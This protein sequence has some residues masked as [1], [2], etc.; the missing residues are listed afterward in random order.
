MNSSDNNIDKLLEEISLLK[1]K[2]ILLENKN[3][4]KSIQRNLIF[5]EQDSTKKTVVYSE[6]EHSFLLAL[7]AADMGVWE[8]DF[9]TN[10]LFWSQKV[11]EIFDITP[12]I[13][14]NTELFYSLVHPEDLPH[15]NREIEETIKS[16]NKITLKYR[17]LNKGIEKWIQCK[18]IVLS[19]KRGNLLKFI[20]NVVDITDKIRSE[21]S[22]KE[23]Q[24]RLSKQNKVLLDLS[25][26]VSG[27]E[28][29]KDSLTTILKS[30][31]EALDIERTGIWLFSENKKKL[32][33]YLCFFAG[34][35]ID[36]K[37]SILQDDYPVYFAASLKEK[38]IIADD[39]FQDQR[40]SELLNYFIDNNISSVLNI[41]LVVNGETKGVVFFEH[42]GKFRRW[43]LDE[44]TFAGAL[45]NMI[46]LAME[47]KEKNRAISDKLQ[48]KNL[49]QEKEQT[50]SMVLDN[51]NYFTYSSE[52]VEGKIV[53]KYISPQIEKIL[54]LT[55]DEFNN[56]IIKSELSDYYLGLKG[57]YHPEDLGKI[58][59][60][61]DKLYL[62]KKSITLYYRFKHKK[63]RKF[64]WLEESVFPRLDSD[65]NRIG[66]FG[67]L[68]DI[69]KIKKAEF[70]IKE[71][72]RTLS[73]L[74]SNLPGLVYRCKFDE[75]FTILFASKGCF[76][77]TGYKSEELLQNN[78]VSFSQLI[79]PDDRKNV[80]D[81]I[82]KALI[83]KTPYELEYRMLIDGKTKWIWEQ[84]RGVFDEKGEILHLEGLILDIS[85]KKLLQQ[86]Q[87]RAE[88]AEKN[89]ELFQ[90]EIKE[91]KKAE[92][93]LFEQAAKL[94]SII[95]SSS[96]MVWTVDKNHRLTSLNSNYTQTIKA[97]F[98]LVP[99]VGDNV[100][101]LSIS[102]L[103][104]ISFENLEK[105]YSEA[106]KGNPQ[107]TEIPVK[108]KSGITVWLDIHLNPI[109]LEKR[110]IM[111]I[112]CIAS[113][114][115][116]KKI[117]EN[118]IRASLKE[119]EVLLKE[120]HHRVKNNLQVISS[121]L[122]LQCS[123]VKDPKVIDVLNESQNRIKSMAF[124]HESL[125]RTKDFSKINFEEYL[126]NLSKNLIHSYRVH[127]N[128]ID[129]QLN[130]DKVYLNLDLA[131]PC[132]LI[133]NEL[134]SNA[135]KYA[136]AGK[137]KGKIE[138]KAV[139][140]TDSLELSVK[141]NGVGMPEGFDLKNTQTLGLQ[142]VDALAE[143][144]KGV[145]EMKSEKNKG[146]S[147]K[148]L[149]N[150][151]PQKTKQ[152]VKSSYSGC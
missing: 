40:I 17:I 44:Q 60:A 87:Q 107:H 15:F 12:G 139:S 35:I 119:K 77:L 89:N 97:T 124:I 59:E 136:F 70:K 21:N 115:T 9:K 18:G 29:L 148:I 66:N 23:I 73:T 63:K 50:L 92:H 4:Q 7:E 126:E 128:S 71:S 79:H 88:L 143:Q 90:N 91:R 8:W 147:Y 69:T 114:V 24:N 117:S 127:N 27:A 108:T 31:S 5:S 104:E 133:V 10:S 144:M 150:Y 51:I 130:I 33:K 55:K 80:F 2:V 146:T 1:K 72:E 56:R 76:D 129:L 102:L 94:N 113:D 141:D 149:I 28:D 62:E 83:K 105:L 95:E 38:I 93:K 110:E 137:K 54:G 81:K 3:I 39:I 48:A 34:E 53:M 41:P 86:E 67:I 140:D 25:F 109:F 36:H 82:S 121:I 19:D 142:L 131:I 6:N 151:K 103:D 64:I 99:K 58:N 74:M 116:S 42:T 43:T 138:I 45:V 84:G 101:E 14:V 75:N 125:Y 135:L 26:I 123:Y 13:V 145:I 57:L 46:A 120:V 16:K 68:R 30:A 32:E 61:L 65:N 98:G 134:I 78:Q 49:L 100:R 112:S 52:I 20:G 47:I 11:Y 85:E 118:L 22:E 96:H 111:E 152:N 106:L 132:G 122:N 37:Y